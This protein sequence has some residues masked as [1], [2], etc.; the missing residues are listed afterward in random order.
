MAEKAESVG[1]G[2][3]N[4]KAERNSAEQTGTSSKDNM[5]DD[6]VYVT[7]DD[8][9]DGKDSDTDSDSYWSP[10]EE[11]DEKVVDVSSS[12]VVHA[13]DDCLIEDNVHTA[14]LKKL[15]SFSPREG[16]R[17]LVTDSGDA[18]YE[19]SVVECQAENSLEQ[20]LIET[21][22]DE[23]LVP[24]KDEPASIIDC[25]KS[26]EP[27]CVGIMTT[28]MQALKDEGSTCLE[29]IDEG[30]ETSSEDENS[31]FHSY[32]KHIAETLLKKT[33]ANNEFTN[34]TVDAIV[35]SV[36]TGKPAWSVEKCL[37][38]YDIV[39]QFD[40]K[41]SQR[42]QLASP[43]ESSN[44][45]SRLQAMA[46]GIRRSMSLRR[47]RA[48]N[49]EIEFRGYPRRTKSDSWAVRKQPI[50]DFVNL[51]YQK[52]EEKGGEVV[53]VIVV[54]P[55]LEKKNNFS[56]GKNGTSD[57][58]QNEERD[59][60]VS[61]GGS[62]GVSHGMNIGN[63]RDATDGPFKQKI[64]QVIS[65]DFDIISLSGLEEKGV[66]IKSGKCVQK[67]EQNKESNENDSDVFGEIQPVRP[68]RRKKIPVERQAVNS[69]TMKRGS[70]ESELYHNIGAGK[71]CYCH[72]H[73]MQYIHTYTH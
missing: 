33:R 39:D 51:D 70:S 20:E 47:P 38:A 9:P 71:L 2:L 15:D 18:F 6:V 69:S 42:V 49:D 63:A 46:A 27:L 56:N 43:S 40:V 34:D 58:I 3:D 17:M 50:D 59:R 29:T 22:A 68:P 5:L 30:G 65:N 48:Q 57:V 7:E 73:S 4:F 36:S 61:D 35:R 28:E 45:I 53:E 1:K 72:C 31:P 32:H 54:S 41:V 60:D 37:G 26:T 13:T 67:E 66:A 55:K 11:G 16:V 12:F 25:N 19:E 52:R 64:S 8:L 62:K 10:E 24:D 23:H 44:L 14:V 21:S